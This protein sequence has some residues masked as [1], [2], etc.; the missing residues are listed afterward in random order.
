MIVE[1]VPVTACHMVVAFHTAAGPHTLVDCRLV[2]TLVENFH[3]H[4][5]V[6]LEHDCH[7]SVHHIH[8]HSSAEKVLPGNRELDAHNLDHVTGHNYN[9][10]AMEDGTW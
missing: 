1:V 4:K 10:P 8:V 6:A 9:L 2:H 5:D 3:V 7:T